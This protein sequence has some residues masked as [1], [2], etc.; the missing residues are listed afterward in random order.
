MYTYD[1]RINHQNNKPSVRRSASGC[2]MVK[3]EQNIWN[4]IQ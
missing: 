2:G 3:V 1:T 4:L